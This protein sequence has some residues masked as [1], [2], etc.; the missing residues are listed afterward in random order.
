MI[1]LIFI[2]APLLGAILSVLMGF[3]DKRIPRYIAAFSMASCL[4]VALF[5]YFTSNGIFKENIAIHTLFITFHKIWF[6]EYG[7]SIYLGLDNLSLLMILLTSLI[8]LCSV[9]CEWYKLNNKIGIFYGFLLCII[10]GMFGIFLSFDM[11][12]FFLFWEL[13]LIPMYFLIIFWNKNSKNCYDIIYVARKFFIYSQIS[14]F[15]LLFFILNIA[16]VYYS[17]FG[18]WTFNYFALKNV[19]MSIYTEFFLMFSLLLSFIIKIP[20]FPFH[21]W[22]PDM[23]EHISPSGSVD[24]IGILLKPAVYGLLRFYLVFFSRTSHILSLFLM[25]IGL[26]SMFYGSIMAFSQKNIKRLLAYSTISSM[27]II[28]AAIHSNSI[29][30][31]QGVLLYLVSSVVSTAALLILNGKIFIHI[32]TQNIYCMNGLWSYMNFIPSFFLFFSLAMLNIPMTGNFSGEFM[33][34]FGI[35]MQYPILGC[36]FI[37]GLFLSS[38]YFLIMIQRVCYSSNQLSIIKN[39]LNFFDFIILFVFVFCLCF[40]G[41]YPKFI[42]KF[43]SDI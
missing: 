12:L 20:L 15:L 28:F 2:L 25:F 43:L 34:L 22:L 42:L 33:M 3:L 21:G 23:Q 37:F 4:L 6:S 29:V 36:F 27:G 40:L 19:K 11:F 24:L 13:I 26:F 17:N 1:L 32:N 7:I 41:L 9:Y 31:Y 39:E 16:C 30:A 38:I 14:G 35:F 5:I 18:I 8:G 10:S